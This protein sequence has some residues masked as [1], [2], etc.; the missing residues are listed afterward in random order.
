VRP[1]FE[2]KEI[3]LMLTLGWHAFPVMGDANRLQQIFWNLFSNA[4]KFTQSVD[5]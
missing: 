5:K 1:A 4:V 3:N 2:A